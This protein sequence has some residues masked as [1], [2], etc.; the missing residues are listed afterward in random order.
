ML[1]NKI[2]KMKII[3]TTAGDVRKFIIDIAE[4]NQ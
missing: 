3:I 4:I 1:K 2:K